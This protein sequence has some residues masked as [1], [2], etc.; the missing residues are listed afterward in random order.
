MSGTGRTVV[1][2]EET[3]RGGLRVRLVEWPRGA[4]GPSRAI[5]LAGLP[6]EL[7]SAEAVERYGRDLMSALRKQREL[8]VAVDDALLAGKGDVR[9]LCFVADGVGAENLYWEMLWEKSEQ[10]LALSP[11]WPIARIT[12]SGYRLPEER[13]FA[14]PLEILAVMS[15]LGEE[16]APE[17]VGLRDAVQEARAAGLPVHVTAVVGEQRLLED[18]Q[19]A[20]A[21]EPGWLT[22][23]ALESKHTLKRLMEDRPPHLLHV[24]CH[25][26]AGHGFG[27]LELATI[28]DRAEPAG[29]A[30]ASVIITVKELSDV[31]NSKQLWLVTLNCCSSAE[32]MVDVQS[33]AQSVINAGASAAVG[34]RE[35]VDARDAN[36]LCRTLYT[37]LLRQLA[38]RLTSTPD[39]ETVLLELATS[40]WGTRDL[41]RSTHGADPLRWTLPV[42]YLAP[43]PL[44][45]QV[46]TTR[47][48]PPGPGGEQAAREAEGPEYK[49]ASHVSTLKGFESVMESAK[50]P[51]TVMQA[52]GARIAA[53]RAAVRARGARGRD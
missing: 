43:H 27:R 28:G 6:Q 30:A 20:A 2:L 8:R 40:S 7:D 51:P 49:D 50:A 25:G 31:V 22:A 1:M 9:P 29:Q 52:I 33:I 39:G 14:A 53:R 37:D 5:K 45:V 48:D 21:A 19:D 26:F 46:R 34:W 35:A 41:L 32:D 42:T 47:T 44:A 3:E 4:P 23:V 12:G 18:L 17:W 24:F 11:R 13:H 38:D 36:L 16:A 10:F 15:A